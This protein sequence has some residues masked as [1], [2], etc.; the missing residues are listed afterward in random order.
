MEA[1][2]HRVQKVPD[3][4]F[5]LF[6]PRGIGKSTWLAKSFPE[7]PKFDLLNHRVFVELATDPTR[8]EAAIGDRP[9]G[10]WVV[11]DEIQKLPILLD[12]VHRLMENR[13]WRFALCG[14]SARKLKR[15]GADL[16]AGR[17]ITLEM[18][19]F[20]YSE[21]GQDFV[22]A[23]ALEWG[24]LPV[25]WRDRGG[26]SDTLSAY[27]NTYLKE[28]IREEGLVRR[29]PPFMRFLEISGL[30]N[31]Q[32][33]NLLNIARDAGVKRGSAEGYFSIITDTLVGHFLP[34][35]NPGVKVR[36]RTH[37]KFYWF[38]NG[39]ARAAAGLLKDH[40][41]SHWLG[42]ALESLIFHELRVYNQVS[43]KQRPLFHYRTLAGSEIDFVVETRR[44]QPGIKQ[45]IVAIEVKL[46]GRWNRS[47]EFQMR[48]IKAGGDVVVE[49]MFGVYTG[50]RSYLFDGLE[51]LPVVEFL[52]KLHEG[53]VF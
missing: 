41:G 21:L 40:P 10:A 4:S 48:D 3:K 27:L 37:P 13:G 22:L 17:A 26:A 11:I 33:V 5:F 7:A 30:M 46:S 1:E 31:G 36:E 8:I 9:A 43:G 49:K 15:G 44:K 47:W 45:A 12:E 32:V 24:L 19:Q 23:D 20:S 34:A 42:F 25:V 53:E 6:G 28:E 39:V 2:I 29:I 38:D 14:S 16:L 35:Y 51:V 50:E 18:E 52:A